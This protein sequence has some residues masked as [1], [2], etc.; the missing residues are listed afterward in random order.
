MVRDILELEMQALVMALEREVRVPS[1]PSVPSWDD[2][3]AP[4]CQVLP[5]LPS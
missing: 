3:G 5:A 4:A 2:A 1:P